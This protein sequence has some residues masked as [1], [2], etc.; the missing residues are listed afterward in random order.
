[1][2]TLRLAAAVLASLLALTTTT[3]ANPRIMSPQAA[4]ES[5]TSK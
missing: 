1:M 3:M 4:V 5:N 2:K